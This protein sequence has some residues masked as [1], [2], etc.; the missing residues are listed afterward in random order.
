MRRL[1]RVGI[2]T[3][4]L[5]T[6][7]GCATANTPAPGGVQA[8]CPPAGPGGATASAP[9]QPSAGLGSGTTPLGTGV[10]LPTGSPGLPGPSRPPSGWL[11]AERPPTS[12]GTC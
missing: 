6:I 8:S 10:G 4:V 11:G 7:T 1:G 5:A 3:A 2:L 12:A 9:S